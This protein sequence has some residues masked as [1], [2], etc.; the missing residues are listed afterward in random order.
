MQWEISQSQH[1]FKLDQDRIADCP[2]WYISYNHHWLSIPGSCENLELPDKVNAL[3][4][5][6]VS[7][8]FLMQLMGLPVKL[9]WEHCASSVK[10]NCKQIWLVTLWGAHK[11]CEG[12]R[13]VCRTSLLSLSPPE[14]RNESQSVY[15]WSNS[16]VRPPPSHY[17]RGI[18]Y[19]LKAQLQITSDNQK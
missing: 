14:A 1:L 6:H 3:R 19:K 2:V 16:Q 17:R 11:E 5:L 15:D 13:D 12:L 18:R 8:I 4:Y 10:L 7:I 9:S